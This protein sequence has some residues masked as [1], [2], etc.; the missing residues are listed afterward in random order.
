M[1]LEHGSAAAPV[2]LGVLGC[3]EIA[4]RR[5]LP[6]VEVTPSVEL[7]AVASRD[8]AK[9]RAFAE[10]FGGDA[11]TGYDA[12]LTRDDLD[13]VYVPLPVGLRRTW[14]TRALEAGLHV[15]SEKPLTTGH[16]TSAALVAEAGRRGLTLLENFAFRHH[17]QH[18]EARRLLDAGAIGSPRALMCE[19]G[20]P[21][22]EP[23]DIRYDPALGGGAL[24]DVGVYPLGLAQFMLGS[25]LRLRGAVLDRYQAEGGPAGSSAA[26]SSRGRNNSTRLTRTASPHRSRSPSGC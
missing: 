19:F 7:A 9:A 17:G 21:E 4:W 6:A 5:V 23:G 18:H 20:V 10:R 16:D 14:V 12:L 3:A 2:R 15:L 26:S 8:P 24:L 1:S 13:A 22:R 11:V 25:D